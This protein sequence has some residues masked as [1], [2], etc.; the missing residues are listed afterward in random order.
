MKKIHLFLLVVLTCLCCSK[1]KV[2]NT[3]RFIPNYNFTYEIDLNLPQFANLK[4]PSNS[5]LITDANIGANGI[6]VFNTGS[7]Y[8]AFDANCPNQYISECSRMYIKSI[9]AVCPCDKAE[10]DLFSGTSAGKEYPM[11]FYRVE[12]QSNII[13]I[14]N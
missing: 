9:S 7:S 14:S 8:N 6:I 2:T 1:D 5:V 3:N 10:Y 11:K 13:R 4:F 12:S